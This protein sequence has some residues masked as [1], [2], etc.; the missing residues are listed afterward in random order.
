MM[1]WAR[2]QGLKNYLETNGTRPQALRLLA[3]L[4]DTVAMDLK[5]PSATGRETWSEHLEFLRAVP[6]K[7]FVKAVLTERSTEAEWRQAMRLMQ[8]VPSVPLV[9]QPSTPF[10]ATRPIEPARV[11]RFLR[12]ARALLKDVRLIPQWHP[13]WG[14]P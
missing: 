8:E 9:L 1:H 2:R 7:I 4:C 14:L 12:L 6:E 10:A 11:L 13:I 3:K 5:L